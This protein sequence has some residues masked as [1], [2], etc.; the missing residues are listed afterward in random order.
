[1]FDCTNPDRVQIAGPIEQQRLPLD[2]L[3]FPRLKQ[4]VVFFAMPSSLAIVDW[5]ADSLRYL[6]AGNDLR[7]LTILYGCDELLDGP[8]WAELDLVLAGPQFESGKFDGIDIEVPMD[9]FPFSEAVEFFFFRLPKT[10]EKK[11]LK[12]VGVS[13]FTS[14][15]WF[16]IS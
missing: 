3:Q 6:G 12:I 10:N 15:Q 11:R 1:M 14:H 16:H 5:L 4:F 9:D 2:L 13:S 8:E 7:S